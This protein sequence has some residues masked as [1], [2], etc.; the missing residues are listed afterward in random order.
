MVDSVVRGLG[1]DLWGV[2]YPQA[3]RSGL[4]RVLIDAPGGIDVDTCARVSRMLSDV[5]DVEDLIPGS[6]RLE[7]SSPGLNR[8]LYT[9]EQFQRYRG[10][11]LRLV[12]NK[13]LPA[14]R[15][16]TVRLVDASP[17]GLVLQLDTEPDQQ[18]ELQ[19][20]DIEKANL[21]P[22]LTGTAAVN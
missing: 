1:V 14:P 8:P 16:I 3:S 11:R 5:L 2:E 18:R 12:L 6:Y 9:L 19:L 13:T 20:N 15:R 17:E 21:V 4:L 22:E 10:C 7:V